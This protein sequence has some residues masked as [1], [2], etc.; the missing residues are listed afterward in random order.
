MSMSSRTRI[1][2]AAV[3]GLVI[4]RGRSRAEKL[5]AL[6]QLLPLHAIGQQP[7]MPD[8]WE[9]DRKHVLQETVEEFLGRKN[10]RL[11]A[12]AIAAITVVV[13]DLAALAMPRDQ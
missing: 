12:V 10:V 1:Q 5:A 4:A 9:V 11:P 6:S 7:V 13:A 2:S 8:A 3:W